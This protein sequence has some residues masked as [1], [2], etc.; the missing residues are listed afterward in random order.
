M[1]KNTIWFYIL[2]ICVLGLAEA[3]A[4]ETPSNIYVNTVAKDIISLE[5]KS[6]QHVEYGHQ[7][8]YEKQ[9]GDKIKKSGINTLLYRDR[10]HIGYLIGKDKDILFTLDKLAGKSLDISPITKPENWTIISTDDQNYLQIKSVHPSS[11]HRKSKPTDFGRTGQWKF[12]APVDHFIYLKLSHPLQIGHHYSLLPVNSDLKPMEFTWNPSKQRSE[13]V[14]VSHLGYRPDDPAKVAFLSCWMGDGGGLSYSE[15]V[16]F[17]VL[18][19]SSH[20]SVF[21][22]TVK[23]SKAADDKTEDAY[24]RNY[25][26]TD[27]YIMDFS[28]LDKPGTY[29]I[30]VENIGCSYSFRIQEDV[31]QD[32]F[33]VSAKGFY[34]QRSG[35]PLEQPYTDFDRPRPF[36]PDD[37]LTVHTSTAPL[38][39]TG[40]GLN[41]NDSNFGNLV[42]GKTDEVVENAWGGY[43]DAGDWDRRIQHLVVTRHLLDLA[44]LFPDYFHKLSL[45]IPESG[46]DLPD[47][48]DEGLFNL[49]CYRRMQTPDGGIR[50]GIEST[51]HPKVGEAS[52]QES[53]TV[54]A[55]APGVWSS[56]LYAATAARAAKLLEKRKPELSQTYLESAIRAMEWAEKELPK[57][58]EEP[59]HDVRDARNLAAAEL[60]QI[61]NDEKWHELFLDTTAFKGPGVETFVWQE[62]EQREAAWVYSN[63]ENTDPD[64][65][66]NCTNALIKEADQRVEQ[67]Y[68]I[69]FRWTK[70]PWA[71]TGYGVLSAPDGVGLVRAHI[72]TGDDKYLKAAV[73]S[74][75][76][77][78]GANP[79]NICYTTGLGYRQPQHPLH[80]DSRITHQSPPPGI[81][82]LGPIDTKN[83]NQEW[84]RMLVDK[85]CYPP[86][87]KWPTI[88]AYWD[89]FWYPIICEFTVQTPMARNAYVWGYLAARQ[90]R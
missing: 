63:T 57:L 51:E 88:E 46:N 25:N 72:L 81:T 55:Y 66:K 3:Q 10:K 6:R 87:K 74:C 40:N 69:G 45:N 84:A 23:L 48:I 15:V 82:V 41:K 67:C 49:D 90:E 21:D 16:K 83:K 26:G 18:D 22:G 12:D 7:I 17:H 76:T 60:W 71:P 13:A 85:F 27:V 62:H 64:I 32:A 24:K 5:I 52:W 39:N 37:G 61:T 47:V 68:K 20:E 77:G 86:V 36:H 38:M 1:E 56:Y 65:K 75:Q 29:R 28:D 89:V 58:E 19:N 78:T 70:Y 31:W 8:P 50:G 2:I 4:E 14:H 59:P 11:I 33:K 79:I 54:M 34:H 80:I 53:L 42:K 44:R 73:L 9:D 43:M 30:Y 35:I